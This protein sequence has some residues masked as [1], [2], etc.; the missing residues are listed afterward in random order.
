MSAAISAVRSIFRVCVPYP[1]PLR[2]RRFRTAA[3]ALP[4]SDVWPGDDA[5]PAEVAE[6][7]LLR[8][9]RLQHEVRRAAL[10]RQTEATLLLTRA[11]IETCIAGLYW[12]GCENTVARMQGNNARSFRRL[13]RPIA[14]G[15]PLPPRLVDDVAA[16]FG[17]REDQ[18][19]LAEMARLVGDCT[20]DRFATDLYER[21][22]IPLSTLS[23]H[24]TGLALLRHVDRRDRT[25]RSGSRVWSRRSAKH[26]ADACAG[27]LATA[28]AA[29]R[30]G[31]L[32]PF[33]AYANAHTSRSITP[34]AAITAGSFANNIR[35]R[36]IPAAYRSLS[37]FRRYYHSDAA[38]TDPRDVSRAR[39]REAL[40]DA[41]AVV[42]ETVPPHQSEMIVDFFAEQLFEPSTHTADGE[43]PRE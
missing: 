24:P 34:L 41:L 4:G 30:R 35:W 20:G 11:S 22:Y 9:L 15:D 32:E 10:L 23:A 14:D 37:A 33:A 2:R 13:L 16:T 43:R 27:R 17:G 1:D 31:T 38:D 6:L 25:T 18:P 26:L 19:S 12:I 8:A 7:A 40:G 39:A 36:K 42:G 3:Y 29:D 21:Y 28:V 5:T